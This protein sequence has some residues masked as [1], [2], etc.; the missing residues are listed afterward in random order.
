MMIINHKT[1]LMVLAG[2]ISVAPVTQARI[3]ADDEAAQAPT[4]LLQDEARLFS[5][6]RMGIALSMAQCEGRELC[7]PSVNSDEI[8]RLLDTL[9]SRIEELTLKQESV[10]DP[11]AFQQV[12]SLYVDERDNYN[13]VLEQLGTIEEDIQDIGVESQVVDLEKA[14]LQDTI[15]EEETFTEEGSEAAVVDEKLEIFQDADLELTDDASL[16]EFE[17]EFDPAE[18]DTTQ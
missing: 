18:P 11:E 7:T 10:E 2:L 13:N 15:S 5:S 14:E 16:E 1:G 4:S 17:D 6:I 8:K 12:L 3:L 9:N